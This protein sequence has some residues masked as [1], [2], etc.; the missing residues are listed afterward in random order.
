MDFLSS[1]FP[2]H[3]A[4]TYLGIIISLACFSLY[5]VLCLH[6]KT[7]FIAFQCTLSGLLQNLFT[8]FTV[9]IANA[10]SRY[11]AYVQ[12][13][14]NCL[15]VRSLPCPL[16]APDSILVHLQLILC[17]DLLVCLVDFPYEISWVFS[18]CGQSNEWSIFLSY[19]SSLFY[20]AQKLFCF[21]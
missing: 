13:T 14:T 21:V 9:D 6:S 5:N 3:I 7:C 16:L 20:D 17:L 15:F 2:V 4:V 18:W 8:W 12:R 1:E 19:F 10:I 11:L